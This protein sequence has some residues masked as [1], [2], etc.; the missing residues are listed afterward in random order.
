MERTLA[1]LRRSM[2]LYGGMLRL[3]IGCV[4]SELPCWWVDGRSTNGLGFVE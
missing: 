2:S 1:D 4:V 3:A